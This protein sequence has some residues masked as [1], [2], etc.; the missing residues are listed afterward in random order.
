MG[1][2]NAGQ[3]IKEVRLHLKLSQSKFSDGICSSIALSRIETG[4]LGVS[5]ST[6]NRLM[7][8]AGQNYYAYPV[9]LNRTDFLCHQSIKK[10]EYLFNTWQFEKIQEEILFVISNNFANNKF[11]YQQI[12]LYLALL[13]LKSGGND[14]DSIYNQLNKALLISFPS[15]SFCDITKNLLSVTDILL[16][17]SIAECLTTMKQEKDA[18][19]LCKKIEEYLKNM[20]ITFK[21]KSALNIRNA[22]V[23]ARAMLGIKQYQEAF[24][25]AKKYRMR[26]IET[27][28]FSSLHE[29]TFVMAICHYHLGDYEEAVK[30]VKNCYYS[31]LSSQSVFATVVKEN[32]YKIMDLTISIPNSEL[33]TIC[34]EPPV[35]TLAT[36][37]PTG[38]GIYEINSHSSIYQIGDIIR[39]V[40]TEKKI[41]QNSLCQGLCSRSTLSKVENNLMPPDKFLLDA[42]L[43]RLGLYGDYFTVYTNSYE[44]EVSELK[45]NIV[46]ALHSYHTDETKAFIN[47]LSDLI[48]PNDSRNQQY[49][50]S[51]SVVLSVNLNWNISVL[52]NAL[53]MT[54]PDFD[55]NKINSYC[56]SYNEQTILNQIAKNQIRLELPKVIQYVY[57]L[58][59]YQELH[60][61]EYI[62]QMHIF[63]VT[64][65]ALIKTLYIE[66]RHK[67]IIELKHHFT[68]ASILGQYNYLARCFLYFA[69]SLEEFG[70]KEDAI[71]N[72][73]YAASNFSIMEDNDNVLSELI[74]HLKDVYGIL[75]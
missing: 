71:L 45:N 10:I 4:R 56:L 57:K 60:S 70:R 20:P 34:F 44:F 39:D 63:P 66:E 46:M 54:L 50:K 36:P 30:W 3:I 2:R 58:L 61:D 26:C 12:Q 74:A 48:K 67:E 53:K 6:F 40:R 11:Y 31:A 72:L 8:R 64:L 25:I 43:E 59:D 68:S 24:S 22:V 5:T 42:L 35:Y 17:I 62:K 55:I 13:Q 41:S 15:T 14:F 51:V 23:Q 27:N 16:L 1:I 33:P 75:L 28:T 9:F 7:E 69:Q 47:T 32:A 52:T 18:L 21:E 37:V 38:N 19:D 73:L 49:L 29:I 65:E